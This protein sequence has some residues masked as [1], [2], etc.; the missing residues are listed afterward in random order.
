M[1]Q[2][3]PIST[4]TK[5]LTHGETG[6]ECLFYNWCKKSAHHTCIGV[7]AAYLGNDRNEYPQIPGAAWHLESIRCLYTVLLGSKTELYKQ[8]Q[9]PDKEVNQLS[10]SI[11]VS[12]NLIE[13]VNYFCWYCAISVNITCEGKIICS[14][15]VGGWIQSFNILLCNL[16]VTCSSQRWIMM[17]TQIDCYF[18]SRLWLPLGHHR[19]FQKMITH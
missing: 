15:Q 12:S 14:D 5:Q 6:R 9:Y 8:F 4:A 11:H 13:G 18:M 1:T 19:C 16:W 17:A 2:E 3:G 7:I 10:V